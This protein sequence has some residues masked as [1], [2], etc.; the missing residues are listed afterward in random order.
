MSSACG[1]QD[2][3]IKQSRVELLYLARANQMKI[4]FSRKGFDDQYGGIPSVI[5]PETKEMLSFPN[6]GILE[7]LQTILERETI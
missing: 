5:W 3:E 2:D 7:W 6:E 1:V 4:I